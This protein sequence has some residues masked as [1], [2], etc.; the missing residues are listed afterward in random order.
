[1]KTRTYRSKELAMTADVVPGSNVFAFP[2]N[3]DELADTIN[4]NA[5]SGKVVDVKTD[6]SLPF[7]TIEALGSN[8]ATVT[9]IDGDFTIKIAKTAEVIRA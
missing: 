3:E 7:A 5:Y 1:M 2:G 4:F 6:K 8:I 9:N